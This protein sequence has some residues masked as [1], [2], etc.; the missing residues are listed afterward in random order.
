[1]GDEER[2]LDGIGHVS[3]FGS[4]GANMGAL[5]ADLGHTSEEEA[6]IQQIQVL[7]LKYVAF[8]PSTSISSLPFA[9]LYVSKGRS[10]TWYTG[11]ARTAPQKE[12]Y[13]QAQRKGGKSEG[14]S[15]W[16]GK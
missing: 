1:M 14:E 10:A 2:L 7:C 8:W 11:P 12:M 9:R 16:Q 4:G 15:S 5:G 6:I 3:T 13:L